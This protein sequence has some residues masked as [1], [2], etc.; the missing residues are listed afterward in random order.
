MKQKFTPIYQQIETYLNELIEKNQH[1]IKFKLPSENQ[2]A[3]KFNAS[4]MTVQRALRNLQD[5]GKIVRIQGKGSYINSDRLTN[6]ADRIGPVYLL[7][8][9]IERQYSREVINGAHAYFQDQG[10]DLSISM[11]N[12]VSEIEKNKIRTIVSRHCPGILLFP[13][14]HM[15]YH[16]ELLNLALQNY[17]VVIVGNSLPGMNFSSVHCDYYRQL[18]RT[19]SHLVK[20]GH[21]NIGYMSEMSQNS[22]TYKERIRGYTDSMAKHV[23]IKSVKLLELDFYPEAQQPIDKAKIESSIHTFLRENPDMTALITTNLALDSI[24]SYLDNTDRPD[25]S[26]VVIDAPE[27]AEP[28]KS[29]DRMIIDQHPFMIGQLAAEQL[30]NQIVNHDPPREIITDDELLEY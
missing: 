14:I 20:K 3:K 16:S 25:L 28:F 30:Y 4:R 19:V 21:R 9:D 26:L 15:T 13:V 5:S 23:N 11:T 2:L 29:G 17:P 27:H 1:E 24:S 12:N 6:D 10:I 8:P 22:S 18:Y 7:L